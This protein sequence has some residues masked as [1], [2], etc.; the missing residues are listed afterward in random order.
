MENESN[1]SIQ[2]RIFHDY[3]ED[4]IIRDISI[5]P[6]EET[7]K[8]LS[9]NGIVFKKEE[10]GF[11]LINT[12][13]QETRD[14]Y[15]QAL[16][17]EHVEYLEFEIISNNTNFQIYTELPIDKLGYFVFS[18]LSY[19][20]TEND[21]ILMLNKSFVED[22]ASQKMGLIKFDISEL[23][24]M[25]D[26]NILKFEIHLEAR[27]TQW[28]YYII[29]PDNMEGLKI[30]NNADIK[31]DDPVNET[32][33]NGSSAMKYSSGDKLIVLEENPSFEILLVDSSKDPEVKLITL[34]HAGPNGL[35][36]KKEVDKSIPV[37]N[38]YVYM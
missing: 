27:K 2:L 4:G 38:I 14:F 10:N 37:S 9:I 22:T 35:E 1:L 21:E 25:L 7:R 34:P 15:T 3:F 30:Q 5:Q 23:I 32:L 28:N 6:T 13:K 18:N 19:E 26:E 11:D 31:F 29:S 33:S 12:S 16:T 20:K 8:L 17:A 36:I 24:N